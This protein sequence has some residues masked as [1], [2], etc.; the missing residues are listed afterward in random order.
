ME[1]AQKTTDQPNISEFESFHIDINNVRII[2]DNRIVQSRYIRLALSE[3]VLAMLQKRINASL[4]A[5]VLFSS[6]FLA[7]ASAHA[8]TSSSTLT[9]N[10]LN[11]SLNVSKSPGATLSGN[12]TNLVNSKK[13][14]YGWSSTNKGVVKPSLFSVNVATRSQM[15]AGGRTIS[16]GRT[17]W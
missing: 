15:A 2:T 3:R 17:T 6:L 7:T 11:V 14:G 1:K 5:I 12:N 16:S 8:F 13:Y 10:A 4:V 9:A